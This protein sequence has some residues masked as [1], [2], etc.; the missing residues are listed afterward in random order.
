MQNPAHYTSNIY[1]TTT[2]VINA[3]T[4]TLYTPTPTPTPCHF[5]NISL[6]ITT[7][8]FSSLAMVM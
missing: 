7:L 4:I 6:I 5:I 3:S 1:P 8:L 2:A